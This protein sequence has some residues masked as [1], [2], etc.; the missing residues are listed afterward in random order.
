MRAE[1][2]EQRSCREGSSAHSVARDDV[3]LPPCCPRINSESSVAIARESS[4]C[5]MKERAIARKESWRERRPTSSRTMRDT[6]H[7]PGRPG[8]RTASSRGAPKLKKVFKYVT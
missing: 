1:G 5:T 8:G 2:P 7:S 6:A 3:E 4:S